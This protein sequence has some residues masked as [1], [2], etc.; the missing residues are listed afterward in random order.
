MKKQLWA[1]LVA[2]FALSA[3]V[4]AQG[5]SPQID[6]TVWRQSESGKVECIVV[7]GTQADLGEALRLARKSEKGRYVFEKLRLTAQES[8]G[9]V[10]EILESHR[11]RYSPYYIVNAIWVEAD[12]NLLN[13]LAQ[14]PE[15]TRI[16]PNTA[17]RLEHPEVLPAPE[18]DFRTIEWGIAKIRADQ[19][20]DLGY[21]GQ[22]VVIGGQDTGYEWNH[23]ALINSY[24]GWNGSTANHHYNWHDAIHEINSHNSGPNPCGLNSLVPC[25][26]DNHGTHTMGTMTGDDG[27]GNQIG[28]APGA[29]WIGCR[30]MERGWGTLS[31]Y[32]ECFQWFLAPTDLNNANPDPEMAPHIINNSWACPPDEGCNSGNFALLQTAIQNCV[33][34]GIAVVASAG[35]SGPSCATVNAPPAIYDLSYSVGATNSADGIASFS[36]RGP[37]TVDGSNR[38]KPDVS[39]PGVGVRSAVR[40]GGYSIFSGTS[41]AGPHVA[42]AMAL[43]IAARPDLAGQVSQLETFLNTT[44]VPL[45]TTQTCGGDTPSSTPNHTFGHGRIDALAAVEAALGTVPSEL[46]RFEGRWREDHVLLEWQTASEENTDYFEVERR[47]GSGNFWELIGK[48]QAAGSSTSLRNYQLRD[49]SPRPGIHYYRL[50]QTDWDGSAHIGPVVAV[51]VPGYLS[52]ETFPNPSPGAFELRV[53]GE[54]TFPLELTWY[55]ILGRQYAKAEVSSSL[56]RWQLPPGIWTGLLGTQRFRVVIR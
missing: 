46:V 11:V 48:V 29:R 14:L 42:G 45:F 49:D 34:A 50:R 53:E 44:S 18:L 21:T 13:T 51:N 31:S 15:V 54:V 41:M 28:V 27:G 17:I 20:W 9:R 12:R 1:I 22:E 3:T 26:D 37:V 47:K 2:S 8:Q 16:D 33:N 52:L 24:R 32:L 4:Y 36:S 7:L 10:L 43:L 5:F 56:S 6:S 55:D 25:D 40:F 39:A 38:L 35:N 23:P 30:N 19:V